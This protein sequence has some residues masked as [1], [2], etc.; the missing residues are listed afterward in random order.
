M[1]TSSTGM[2]MITSGRSASACATNAVC[3]STSS[4]LVGTKC[5]VRTPL[6]PATRSVARRKAA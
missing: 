2:K 3:S 4:G 5:T 1:A 6:A